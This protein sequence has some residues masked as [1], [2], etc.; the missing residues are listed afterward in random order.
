MANP[1]GSRTKVT[2][3]TSARMSKKGPLTPDALRTDVEEALSALGELTGANLRE[4]V[5]ARIFER[6][7]VG[8]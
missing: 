1:T 5:T 4:D 8:K 3:K 6:F 7:C 2:V